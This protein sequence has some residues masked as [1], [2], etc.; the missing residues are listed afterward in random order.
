MNDDVNSKQQNGGNK[1]ERQHAN[2]VARRRRLALRGFVP[3]LPRGLVALLPQQQKH[4]HHRRE[5]DEF[6]SHRVETPVIEVHGS[7]HV[8]DMPLG[9]RARVEQVAIG[10]AVM[11]KSWNAAISQ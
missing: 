7:H 2:R 6:F 4:A 11:S 3:R 8:C 1:R 10:A 9:D 5:E